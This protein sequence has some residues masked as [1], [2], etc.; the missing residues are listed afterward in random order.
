ME[1]KKTTSIKVNPQ[2]WKTVKKYCIDHDIDVSDFIDKLIDDALKKK[3]K[4][5]L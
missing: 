3:S 4:P 2:K 5:L 1:T